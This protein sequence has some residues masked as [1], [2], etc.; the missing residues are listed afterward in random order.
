MM[1][2]LPRT[3]VHWKS[4]YCQT[5]LAGSPTGTLLL[6]LLQKL[7]QDGHDP[8]LKGAVVAVRHQHV[9]YSVPALLAQ[10]RTGQVEVS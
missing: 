5:H 7:I 10:L 8:I 4:K 6:L 1:P 9:P 2:A 3:Q